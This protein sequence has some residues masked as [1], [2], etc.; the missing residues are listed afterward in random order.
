MTWNFPEL[1]GGYGSINRGSTTCT[2]E[3]KLTSLPRHIAV[4]LPNV[5]A[6][7]LTMREKRQTIYT[8]SIIRLNDFPIITKC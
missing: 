3:G 5:K 7:V 8:R 2:K 6:V 4:K 1:K